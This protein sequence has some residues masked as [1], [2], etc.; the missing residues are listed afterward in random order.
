MGVEGRGWLWWEQRGGATGSGESRGEGL[1]VGAVNV[2]S[3]G[4]KSGL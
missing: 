2:S 1:V 4:V 3:Y